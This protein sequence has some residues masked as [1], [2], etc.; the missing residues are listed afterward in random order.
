MRLPKGSRVLK[1]EDNVPKVTVDTVLKEYLLLVAQRDALEKQIQQLKET[2]VKFPKNVWKT[3]VSGVNF[4]WDESSGGG[5]Q[6]VPAKTNSVLDKK[7]AV[8]FCKVRKLTSC[9]EYAL[10]EQE[11]VRAVEEGS[12]SPNDLESLMSENVSTPYVRRINR[13]PEVALDE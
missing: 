1:S 4:L 10:N 8:E 13:E 9:L 5:L 12:V 6:F 3:S 7:A 11:F 2:I